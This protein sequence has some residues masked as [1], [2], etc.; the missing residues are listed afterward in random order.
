M[1]SRLKVENGG[2]YGSKKDGPKACKA[3]IWKYKCIM[4]WLADRGNFE[5]CPR[6]EEGNVF[7][8]TAQDYLGKYDGRDA[9]QSGRDDEMDNNT[10]YKG[11]HKINSLLVFNQS[12]VHGHAFN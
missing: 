4:K 1:T 6:I 9:H 5:S 12:S 3:R 7:G 2:A 10:M 11:T 8:L